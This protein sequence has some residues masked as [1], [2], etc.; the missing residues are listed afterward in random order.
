[1]LLLC[2]L[3]HTCQEACRERWLLAWAPGH[4]PLRRCIPLL[5]HSAG[6]DTCQPGVRSHVSMRSPTPGTVPSFHLC[7]PYRCDVT[8]LLPFL[9]SSHISFFPAEIRC[10]SVPGEG[11]TAGRV[12]FTPARS[13]S[14]WTR[15]PGTWRS[16]RCR[17]SGRSRPRRGTEVRTGLPPLAAVSAAVWGAGGPSGAGASSSMKPGGLSE[18]AGFLPPGEGPRGL[19]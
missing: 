11:T 5:G 9:K 8:S 7:R 13:G 14:S 6:V 17:T 10:P 16:P 18:A 2:L 3:V 1:M 15:A 12:C 4:L 19:L